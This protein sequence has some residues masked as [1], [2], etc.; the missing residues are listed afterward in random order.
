[1]KMEINKK[2]NLT[3]SQTTKQITTT[4]TA[5]T[6]LITLSILS[7]NLTLSQEGPF[8][9]GYPTYF[10]GAGATYRV[11]GASINPQFNN[12]SFLYTTGYTNPEVYW[13]KYNRGDCL[14][15]Q[16]FILQIAPGGCSPSVVTS[17]LLEE[18]PVPVFCKVSGIQLNPLI[19]VS[20]IRA[21]RFI[22]KYPKGV[23]SISYFPARASV[24]S[25]R[26][27]I[28]SPV[29]DNMGY[30]VIVLSRNQIEGEMPDYVEGNITA[31]I[32]YDAEGAY[33]IGQAN[34]Y[35]TELSDQDWQRD[36]KNYGFWNGR[37]Y[38]RAES[39]EQI[40][41]ATTY[42]DQATIS[43]YRDAN[44]KQ[45]TVTLKKGETSRDIFLSGFYCAAGMNIRLDNIKSP[46][47]TALLQISDNKNTQQIWV[48]RGDR[49]LGGKCW[50]TDLD[51]YA[52]GGKVDINC[53]VKDGDFEL[54]LT[55]GKATLELNEKEQ[56]FAI[57][58]KIKDNIFLAYAGE[59][60]EN[61]FVVLINDS[62]SES[63]EG[64]A[65]KETYSVI[66]EIAKENK[67]LEQLKS[68]IETAI[69]SQ[70]RKKLTIQKIN[71][72]I[73]V[74]IL[75]TDS[76]KYGI[77]LRDILIAKN[78]EIEPVLQQYYDEAIRYYE[79][80]ADL[81]PNEKLFEG[82]DPYAAQGLYEAANL[83]GKFQQN[84]KAQEL[85]NRLIREYPDSDITSEALRNQ[86]LLTKY[87][88]SQS[89]AVVYID[90]QPY[91]FDLLDLK[92]PSKED[93]NAVFLINGEEVKLGLDEIKI[94]DKDKTTEQTKIQLK[95]INDERVTISYAKSKDD[96]GTDSKTRVIKLKEQILVHDTTIKLLN[97]NLKKQVK[98]TINPKRYGPRTE[99]DFKF[100]IG[101]EKRAVK[102]SPEKTNEMIEDMNE[103]INKW[104]EVN[105]KL[106]KVIK[107]LKGACFASAAALT[108]KNLVEG[109]SGTSMARKTLMT[110]SGGWN[111]F[112]EELVGT[113][114][115]ST[116]TGETYSSVQSCLL[117][118]NSQINKD[119]EIY[120]EQIEKTNT[121]LEAIQKRVGIDKT[122][123]L[124]FQGQTDAKDVENDF[125]LLFNKF[126]QD[127][128]DIIILPNKKKTPVQFSEIC[129]WNTTT[130]EQ[131]REL[132]T[133]LNARNAAQS[134]GSSVLMKTLD[135]EL[136]KITLQ[137]KNYHE[138]YGAQ[139]AAEQEARE[140]GLKAT[141]LEGEKTAMAEIHTVKTSDNKLLKNSEIKPGDRVIRVFIPS[142]VPESDYR[143]ESE[144]KDRYAIIKLSKD[145]E[146]NN[147]NFEKAYTLDGQTSDLITKDVQEYLNL[148]QVTSFKPANTKAYINPMLHPGNLKVKYFER[149]PYKGLPAEIPFDVENGWYVHLTYVLSGFG[150]PYDESG[151]AVNYYICNVGPNGLIEFKK[152]ADDICRYYNGNTA[153][154]NFPGMSLG[155][156]R[157]LINRAQQAVAEAGRQYGQKT[158]RIGKNTF[159]SAISFEGEE[160][161]CSDFMSPQDCHLL[162]NVCDPVIC[163]A[164][165]CD[166]GGDFRVDNVIQTGIIGS[167]M[168]CLPN[169]KE[170][171]FVPIC[172]SGVH[173]GIEGYT[174]ILNSTQACLKE[175]LETGRNIGICDE[176]KSIYL[177]E[178]FWK[179]ATPF[180]NVLIPRVIES[181]FS[182]GVRGGGEYL[183]VMSAWDNAQS[184]IDYFKNEY[185]INS[186]QAFNQRSTEEIGS[187]I[188]K[189][190]NSVVYPASEELFDRLIEP[191]SPVQYH[192]WFSEDVLTTATIPSTSHYKVYYHIY[193][194]KDQGAYY[195]VYLKD[196]PESNYIYTSGIY[197]VRTG[198]IPRGSQIDEARDF[199]TVSGYK[200]LC[201][202]VNGQEQ[203]G[204]GKVTTS[205]FL[206]TLTDF[207][208]E[209]QLKTGIKSEKEC[210]S[211]TPSLRTIIQPDIQAGVEEI[212]QPSLYNHGIIRI[213]ST[214]NPGKTVLPTGEYDATASI[215]DKWKEVG[216]CDDPTIKC[217]LDTDSV[218]NVIQDREIETEVLEEV[219]LSVLGE[220]YPMDEKASDTT[221][222]EA[223]AQ[224]KE[225]VISIDTLDIKNIENQI[226]II[227]E[228]LIKLT[229]LGIS[230]KHR[231]EGTKLLGDLYSG[232]AKKL[233]QRSKEVQTKQ[234]EK[235]QEGV[236]QAEPSPS[237]TISKEGFTIK[238]NKIY[239]N[240][241][242]IN[243]DLQLRQG[244]YIIYSKKTSSPVRV[245]SIIG[246]QISF[247]V[248][249]SEIPEIKDL[250]NYKFDEDSQSFVEN[251]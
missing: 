186:M 72:R 85:Y 172:L 30:V 111:D 79:D 37:A 122:D 70:Y 83:A 99:S 167:L 235:G 10:G 185:A 119:I 146:S 116:I 3:K 156:S 246:S 5:L 11:Y 103:N 17:D 205:Y 133:L 222:G 102:L 174:S 219:D 127:K 59:T 168:L 240:N 220:E 248:P 121:E 67:P 6:L 100:R 81:Y 211:G 115:T 107:G 46:V 93:A 170:G 217:W 25:H 28:S 245:G 65:E 31:I 18:Q 120:K 34:F 227:K 74:I 237:D 225:I 239:F 9:G 27:L 228:K 200:Q 57:G 215:H 155:E 191:D 1:M 142:S 94:I 105:E 190:Y 214:E 89:K 159:G 165:R 189:S 180:I 4:L 123:I 98:L 206:N 39:I 169:A 194:G 16:D 196:L 136:G 20:H 97:T 129:N 221:V 236:P 69:I 182:Q 134:E 42:R 193:S 249:E 154:L 63:E 238:N 12:P 157:L 207:Y 21:L 82:Q 202:S 106:G 135:N 91:F 13:P 128:T 151:R 45:A 101:I 158:V 243:Y 112:C 104:T 44:I 114:E 80:L 143:A 175:S 19:D 179:Q 234:S 87:D 216:H 224:I 144:I 230:N 84:Q 68:K 47:E 35:V 145:E 96:T 177:C 229:N 33:G 251:N 88:S 41:S 152:S 124:D 77:I 173:A 58:D 73:E 52:G 244:G 231:A 109:F 60:Q 160:G 139:I 212:L 199:T 223:R 51:A 162:F 233:F 218:K 183:T 187:E 8:Y 117:E 176:I 113:K 32:D 95:E 163:P 71:Q 56:E 201:I 192:A 55:P 131:K 250:K 75:T 198:Y 181:F 232:I 188:C 247:E 49:V 62:F 161:R 132:M 164:S 90:N 209:E 203:C 66:E 125:S 76:E 7:I 153:D 53:R 43:V 48:A 208:A 78:K 22:G 166:L 14:E 92:K 61:N 50:V 171:I 130:H 137:A 36:Y 110:A 118:H 86:E 178:F 213:C 210:I 64:F 38:I 242:Y 204:F 148:R 26:Q 108:V 24:R 40:P 54:S 226:A 241:Q 184:A 141:H 197:I 23:S 149:T 140:Y 195:A 29:K 138:Y 15:R 147:Y 2:Q 126:C 150:K